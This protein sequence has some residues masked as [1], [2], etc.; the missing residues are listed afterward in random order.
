MENLEKKEEIEIYDNITNHP[1]YSTSLIK[2]IVEDDTSKVTIK[3]GKMIIY[4]P[5]RN[6]GVLGLTHTEQ[7]KIY[8]DK[9]GKLIINHDECLHRPADK[10]I[11]SEERY[12]EIAIFNYSSRGFDSDGYELFNSTYTKNPIGLD[13]SNGD[14]SYFFQLNGHSPEWS[15]GRPSYN[16]TFP[17]AGRTTI[18]TRSRDNIFVATRYSYEI[19]NYGRLSNKSTTMGSTYGNSIDDFYTMEYRHQSDYTFAEFKPVTEGDTTEVKWVLT[20]KGKYYHPNA[21]TIDD[22]C[23][24]IKSTQTARFSK[25]KAA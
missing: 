14:I 5:E 10:K 21:K 23:S 11:E 17:T 6:D 24:E 2:H 13:Y 20:E 16:L 4:M 8:I 1:G 3:D 18:T 25:I 7:Y 12:D 9:E 22:V 15:E 19:D